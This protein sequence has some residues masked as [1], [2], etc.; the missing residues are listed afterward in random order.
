MNSIPTSKNAP[1]QVSNYIEGTLI[2]LSAYHL[3]SFGGG[4]FVKPNMVDFAYVFANAG[5]Q[6]N[7]TIYLTLIITVAFYIVVV[8]WARSKDKKDKEKV[9]K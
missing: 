3:T 8:L 6:D 5:F 4:F 2:K 1:F 7:I 9:T